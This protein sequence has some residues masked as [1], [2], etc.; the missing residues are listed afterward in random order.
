[1]TGG[2]SYHVEILRKGKEE[3]TPMI[4]KNKEEEKGRETIV[5]LHPGGKET[6]PIILLREIEMIGIINT[7]WT[8][9]KDTGG[10]IT[11]TKAGILTTDREKV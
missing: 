11:H 10:A 8:V 5:I 2:A 1:M 4:G 9:N 6:T 7:F 3:E